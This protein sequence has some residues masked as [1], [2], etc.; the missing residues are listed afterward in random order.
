[1]KFRRIVVQKRSHPAVP[2][3]EKRSKIAMHVGVMIVMVR[4]V[5]E[6]FEQPVLRHP[7]RG[8]FMSRV[9]SNVDHRVVRQVSKQHD[10]LHRNEN[11]NQ[12]EAEE[13]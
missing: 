8:D 5:V 10:W 13:L 12:T 11:N 9:A 1:M 4:D 2:H 6:A 7:G 3:I